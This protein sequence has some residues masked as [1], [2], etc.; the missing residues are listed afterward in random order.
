M[1]ALKI[2]WSWLLSNGGILMS[3]ISGIFSVFI[4][5]KKGRFWK[6]LTLLGVVLGLIWALASANFADREQQK[7]MNDA[8][9]RVDTYVQQRS[10]ETV[11]AVDLNM[12]AALEEEMQKHFGVLQQTAQGATLQRTLDIVNA[13]TKAS[14]LT[15]N[16]PEK[17][18]A[19]LTIWLFPHVQQEIDYEAFKARLQRLALHVQVRGQKVNSEANS[20]WWSEG[21]N[22]DE[23]KAVAL[24]A[25]S[26]GLQIKQICHNTNV[27]LRNLIQIGGSV[28]AQHLPPLLPSQIE[29]LTGP[30]CP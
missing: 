25:V 23:A 27:P 1:P 21:S 10:Q 4:G 28:A 22:L 13:A 11:S 6:V 17:R 7:K 30:V 14:V 8:I 16:W 5:D 29:T 15:R 2:V 3:G 19:A 18:R 20:V 24:T 26:A 9:V 12:R